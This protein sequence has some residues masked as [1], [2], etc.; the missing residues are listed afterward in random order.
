MNLVPIEFENQRIMTTKILAEQFGTEDRIISNNFNRNI[1]RFVEGKHYYK[2]EG[3]EL[4][5]FKTN[6][7]ND[8]SS[9]LRINCLYLW[10]D[11]GAARHAKILETDEAWQVYETLEDTYFNAKQLMRPESIEDLII[12]Q[13]TAMKQLRAEVK[14]LQT[15]TTQAKHD[16]QAIRDIVIVAPENQRRYAVETL[17]KIG[18][19]GNG[20]YDE[21]TRKSYELLEERAGCD[22]ERRLD[23]RKKRAEQLGVAKS[24]INSFNYLDCIFED[25]K[26]TEI[27]LHIIKELAIKNN[28]A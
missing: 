16:V 27:Y 14:Q 24:K 10:T 6:H 15:D 17:R 26:L 13:A 4:A 28:I 20:H 5:E 1:E 11:R 7:L 22:L 21:V 18:Y 25:K 19:K 12:M 9:M 2:L 3:T 23:G 8:E